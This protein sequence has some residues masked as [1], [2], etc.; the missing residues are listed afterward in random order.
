MPHRPLYPRCVYT[1]PAYNNEWRQHVCVSA[2]SA[3]P[4]AVPFAKLSALLRE[5]RSVSDDELLHAAMAAAGEERHQQAIADASP[6]EETRVFV[7][8]DGMSI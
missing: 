6:G 5:R 2:F 8:K 7:E 4:C 1:I 3:E